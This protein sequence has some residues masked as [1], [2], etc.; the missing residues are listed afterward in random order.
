MP[1][2]TLLLLQGLGEV[3]LLA[4]LVYVLIYE[5]RHGI[6]SVRDFDYSDPKANELLA[7]T[8]V[9]LVLAVIFLV[10]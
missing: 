6:R 2:D 3:A 9:I 5:I 7:V 4:F 1:R 10:R 8:T